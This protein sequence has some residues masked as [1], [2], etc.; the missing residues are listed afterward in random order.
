M[1]RAERH[2]LHGKVDREMGALTQQPHSRVPQANDVRVMFPD[3]SAVRLLLSDL[4][5]AD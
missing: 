2:L 4:M 5:A 1:W 3:F